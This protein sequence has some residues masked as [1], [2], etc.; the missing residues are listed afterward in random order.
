MLDHVSLQVRR[1][2]RSQQAILR[3]GFGPVGLRPRHGNRLRCRLSEALD[4]RVLDQAGRSH[5]GPSSGIPNVGLWRAGPSMSRSRVMIGSR[6]TPSTTL[7]SK[8]VHATM[9]PRA[10]V[11]TTTRTITAP[12]FSIQTAT[13]LKPCAT[14]RNHERLAQSPQGTED[15]AQR[16][17]HRLGGG[18]RR[19]TPTASSALTY[20]IARIIY[21]PAIGALRHR[22]HAT[23][24]ASAAISAC[25]QMTLASPL[26]TWNGIAR[27]M[28]VANPRAASGVSQG[29]MR[30]AAGMMSPSPPAISA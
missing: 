13:T 21:R 5:A 20:T 30:V 11:P 3:S 16:F 29:V 9:A 26:R 4:P 18:V 17:A 19:Q 6:S 28:M 24:T 12:S 22:P 14:S 23:K 8:P 25:V 7:P 1:G 2:L 10:C 15:H 27:I